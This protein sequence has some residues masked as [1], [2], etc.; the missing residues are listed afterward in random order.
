MRLSEVVHLVGLI[1]VSSSITG[2]DTI[3]EGEPRES[4]AEKRSI[5]QS[6][7]Y[8]AIGNALRPT[9][10]FVIW[11]DEYRG[12]PRLIH[13]GITYEIIRT[14]EIKNRKLELVCQSLDD[15]QTNLSRLRDTVEIWH[16]ALTENSMGEV[17]PAAER[18]YTVP[19]QVQYKGGGTTGTEDA[20]ETIN[21]L[22]VIIRYKEGITP[23]MF[24]MIDGVRHDIRYIEDPYNRHETLVLQVER[25]TL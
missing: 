5:R 18:L 25:V 19:A 17:S 1:Y 20:I 4:L 8:E 6:E 10:T 13:D 21:D 2:I 15:V 23:D 16:I 11:V 3:I 14:F 22:T 12:E 24:L 7:F 9:A